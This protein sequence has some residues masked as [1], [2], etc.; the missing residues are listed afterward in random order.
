[1]YESRRK[2][3][4][5]WIDHALE[6]DDNSIEV[7]PCNG[8]QHLRVTPVWVVLEPHATRQWKKSAYF[9][10]NRRGS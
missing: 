2:M 6:K 9:S 7:M 4:W 8:T 3:K 5:Q 1:M 10:E